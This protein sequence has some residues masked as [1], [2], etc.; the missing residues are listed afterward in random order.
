MRFLDLSSLN[1]LRFLQLDYK[2]P[3]PDF[4]KWT[5][6]F[7]DSSLPTTIQLEIF[8]L[9][10]APTLDRESC[11]FIDRMLVEA[12]CLSKAHIDINFTNSLSLRGA[13]PQ[14][15]LG[16]LEGMPRLMRRGG[17]SIYTEL[18]LELTRKRVCVEEVEIAVGQLRPYQ[19]AS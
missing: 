17:I 15:I 1:Q 7:L 11:A 10:L 9:G 19:S 18:R 12:P 4:L 5:Q 6:I 14:G 3:T 2:G 13:V 16:L 8:T